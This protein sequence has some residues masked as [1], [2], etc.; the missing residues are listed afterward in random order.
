MRSSARTAAS[1]LP[2]VAVV[3][4]AWLRLERPLVELWRGALLALLALA[5]AA[6][7]RRA[8]RAAGAVVA[9]LLAA[10]LAFGI[11]LLP[12]RPLHPG[13]GFGLG[14]P[15][16][17]LG[18][19]VGNGFLAFYSVHLPFDARVQVDMRG[20]VL[21]ALFL[22]ALL[23]AL[24]AA[25]R[26]A[27]VAAAALVVGAGWPATL[28]D[29]ARGLVVGTAILLAACALLAGLGPRRVP[30]LVVPAAGVVALAAWGIGAATAASRPLVGW[31]GWS[32]GG[33]PGGA[34][35]VDFVWNAQYGGLDW[36]RRETVVLQ[37][38]SARAPR[39]LR[40]AVLDDF[41]GDAWQVGPPRPAD[42]LEPAAAL[43]AANETREVVT[44]A[45]LSG[46]RLVGG[47]VPVRF[48]AGGAP[49]VTPSPGFALLQSGL[50]RDFRYTAWSYAPR[51]SAAGLRR[52]PPDYPATL[53][54]QG[55]LMVGDG[56]SMP[57]FGVADRRAQLSELEALHPSLGPYLPLG[58]LAVKV[59]GSAGTPYGAVADLERWFLGSGGFSYSDH[60]RVVSPPLVG[61]VTETHE[62]YCQYFAGAM[63][64]M[65]RYLGIPA[66]VAVG[67][68]G[69]TYEAG[70][71]AW[72]VTDHDAHA[73]VEAWFKGYGWLPFD[74]TPT[75]GG[76]T[77]P[78]GAGAAT[79][80]YPAGVPLGPGLLSR[81]GGV[82]GLRGGGAGSPLS[83]AHLGR[84]RPDTVAGRG[85]GPSAP[86]LAVL[87]LAGVVAAVVAAKSALRLARRRA[88]D[89]RRV[90]VACR[91][92][93]AAFL[94]DQGYP[95]ARGASIQELADL[96]RR[97]TGAEPAGFVSAALAARFAPPA[98]AAAA[99]RE[100][101]AELRTLLRELRSGLRRR[102]RLLG[103]LSPRSLVPQRTAVDGS[104]SLGRA[105]S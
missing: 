51:L 64:L 3:A 76:A 68:S 67:F 86:L 72:V 53:A 4:L 15:L 79:A 73:W 57:A 54:A 47:S 1:V 80:G 41:V 88:H 99:A 83:A 104:A 74:P 5:V 33:G 87:V 34:V 81:A 36:P 46:S 23:V 89:P 28:F 92:E 60:P 25:E 22:F 17:D 75:T 85:G 98:R 35:G 55:M 9:A 16:S 77:R 63:A 19:R 84:I 43:R 32:P 65:L 62:G 24:L 26:A 27:V 59:A 11:S 101:R 39:Y 70:K 56:V 66:R 50:T 10:W 78:G 45:A 71:H 30:A 29:P 13:N 8:L 42:S 52:S 12:P 6:L 91:D 48:S 18:R 105:G 61:F 82:P 40:A 21:V 95:S 31:Q 44:V 37:V 100:A 103:L 20:L 102:D 49:L 38:Q 93:L 90:A 69:G 97:V 7:P 96:T 58:R 94:V 14:T 2:A